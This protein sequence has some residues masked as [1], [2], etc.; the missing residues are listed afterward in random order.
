MPRVHHV[1]TPTHGRILIDQANATHA[2][3]VLVA[4]HGYG[5]NAGHALEEA[6]R[7]PGVESWHV[8]AVQALHRF[9][10]REK[11][12]ASWMTREDRELAI[13][14]NVQYVNRAIETVFHSLESQASSRAPLVLF[15]FSQGV[16]MA[17][18]A[19]LLG[20]FPVQGIIAL[21]GDI[22]PEL[23]LV[24]GRPWPR[25]L[26][27]AGDTDPFYTAE[28]LGAD[29]AFLATHQVASQVVRFVGGHDST[30]E[31]RR[32]A[33]DWL[34]EVTRSAAGSQSTSREATRPGPRG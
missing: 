23:G 22:P 7:I 24:A 9:Y 19:A 33:A 2:L 31:F 1:E 34:Q 27:G 3:G 8:A 18:R 12:V 29:E 32:A 11:I 10:A 5:Q 17:Y 20:S 16:P 21:A 6:R 25:V 4:F 14:D 28:K 13:V 30:D 15:G 26:I